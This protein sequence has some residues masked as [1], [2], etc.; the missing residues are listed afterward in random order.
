MC[1][2]RNA[3][4]ELYPVGAGCWIWE[5]DVQ[6]VYWLPL[7]ADTKLIYEGSLIPESF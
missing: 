7:L 1:D 5:E 2:T 6:A 3:R 4:P